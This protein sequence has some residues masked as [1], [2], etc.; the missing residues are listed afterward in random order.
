MVL[1]L[2]LRGLLGD[3]VAMELM[4]MA[5]PTTSAAQ[6]Q[7]PHT[8]G[9]QHMPDQHA[10]TAMHH[11]AVHSIHSHTAAHCDDASHD[12]SCSSCMLCHSLGASPGCTMQLDIAP[13]GA[14]IASALREPLSASVRGLFKPPIA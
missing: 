1:L 6:Q 7:A 11:G 10:E 5:V 4:S 14:P 12:A 9:P 8:P 13:R 3:A 2:V